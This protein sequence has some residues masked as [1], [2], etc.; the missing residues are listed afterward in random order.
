LRVVGITE[1][2]ESDDRYAGTERI[3]ATLAR[4]H[5]DALDRVATRS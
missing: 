1:V 4:A 2:I 3:G 5:D